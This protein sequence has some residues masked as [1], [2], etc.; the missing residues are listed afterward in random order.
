MGHCSELKLCTVVILFCYH[1]LVG[2]KILEQMVS[3]QRKKIF[4]NHLKK[5]KMLFSEAKAIFACLTCHQLH[6]NLKMDT[7]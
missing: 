7:K 3:P 6:V 1:A 4:Y 2:S 5:I